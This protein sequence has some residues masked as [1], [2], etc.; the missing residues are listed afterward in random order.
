MADLGVNRGLQ[1]C[2]IIFLAPTPIA[3]GIPAFRNIFLKKQDDKSQEAR[4]NEKTAL[5]LVFFLAL[6]SLKRMPL[7]LGAQFCFQKIFIKTKLRQRCE[8]FGPQGRSEA[9]PET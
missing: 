6:A 4:Q 8:G 1:V 3:I 9:Q 2:P 7:Q 5:P